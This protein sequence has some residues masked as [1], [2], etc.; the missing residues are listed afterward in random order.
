MLLDLVLGEC[1][2][3]RK[4]PCKCQANLYTRD[5]IETCHHWLFL[6]QKYTILL[7]AATG[8]TVNA[9]GKSG[10]CTASSL[11]PSQTCRKLATDDAAALLRSPVTRKRPY[12]AETALQLPGVFCCNCTTGCP[13][14]NMSQ[15]RCPSSA[16]GSVGR[17][18]V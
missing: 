17:L 12:H 15:K 9:G 3:F 4:K 14:H 13:S 10:C 18:K 8:L 16:R 7:P 1:S 11:G 6:F 5:A 2:V